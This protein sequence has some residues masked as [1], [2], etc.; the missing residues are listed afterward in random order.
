MRARHTFGILAAA[1]AVACGSSAIPRPSDGVAPATHSATP[2][3]TAVPTAAPAPLH[4][5]ELAH[6]LVWLRTGG[7]RSLELSAS[8][9]GA[10]R[11][12]LDSGAIAADWSRVY[13][14]FMLQNAT[15][16]RAFDPAT[17]AELAHLDVPGTWE[18][19][20]AAMSGVP[21]AVAAGGRYLT[22]T[23]SLALG[24]PRRTTSRFLLVDTSLRAAPQPVE[25]HGDFL[26]DGLSADGQ[27]LFLLENVTGG[28]N[29]ALQYHVRRYDVANHALAPG[30]IVDKRSSDGNTMAGTPVGRTTTPD[31]RWQLTGY[32][33][34]AG[35]PFVHA[36]NLVDSTAVCLDLP[37]TDDPNGTEMQLLWSLTQTADHQRVFAVNGGTGAVVEISLAGDFPAVTRQRMLAV[38]QATPPSPPS[39]RTTAAAH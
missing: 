34:G 8:A 10:T 14:L 31:G 23:D 11:R 17:G 24:Q 18:L 3:P 29:Q 12:T 38:P 5:G 22:L 9:D 36:L 2:L 30:I 28:V 6:Y 26:F 39:F 20:T 15:R 27:R 32:A 35:G 16:I 33:F 4:P 7:P 1:T 25:L 37:A 19:P 13:T 21:D